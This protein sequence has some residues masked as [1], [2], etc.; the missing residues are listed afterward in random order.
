M[1]RNVKIIVFIIF[2]SLLL[3]LIFRNIG[4][5]EDANRSLPSEEELREFN[6]VPSKN[7]ANSY[8]VKDIPDREL[9][10]IYY[11]HFKNLVVNN[12]EEAY[13]RIRNKDDVSR[14]DFEEFRADLINNYYSNKVS[15]YRITNSDGSSIYRIV[16]S[17]EE[18]ITFYVDAVFFFFVELLL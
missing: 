11:N 9:A 17:N 16:N 10:T 4:N 3:F 2:V 8:E 14:E 7:S 18:T 1:V 15:S 12:E 5:V 6:N 13:A